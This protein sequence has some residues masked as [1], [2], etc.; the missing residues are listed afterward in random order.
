[1]K[2]CAKCKEKKDLTL[3]FNNKNKKD[4][5]YIYCKSC[6]SIINKEWRTNNPD[7]DKTIHKKYREKNL[8]KLKISFSIYY[9]TNKQKYHDHAKTWKKKNKNKVREYNKKYHKKRYNNDI[10]YKLKCILRNRFRKLVL[11]INKTNSC[12]DLLG[13]DIDYFK[14]YISLKFQDEMSWDNYGLWHIDHIKPCCS[15]DLSKIEDQKKCFHYTN[16]Q[17]LWAKDNLIKN[18][19]IT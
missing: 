9:R 15:F 6:C 13:C 10:N 4:G 1:M 19:K 3:F 2:I 16:M 5:K 8:N 7:K 14:K 11:G 12:L 17:P 18:G